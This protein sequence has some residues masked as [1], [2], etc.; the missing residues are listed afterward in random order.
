MK[1]FLVIG[2]PIE[3]SLSPKLH[4]YWFKSY[5]MN[6]IYG[7]LEASEK[8]LPELCKSIKKGDLDGLNVT[9]PFKKSIIPYLDILSGDALRTQSV[10]TISLV[11]GNLIGDNTDIEGFELSLKKINYDV[12]GKKVLILGAGGVVPS[13]ICALQ[14]M[15]AFKIFVSNR[16]KKKADHLKEMFEKIDVIEWGNLQEFDII[17]NATTLGL[18]ENDTFGLDFS[19][20]GENKFFY[21]VIYAP[22]STE[23][24]EAGSSQNNLS[25]NGFNMFLYQAQKAFNIW[26][27]I[28]PEINQELLGFLKN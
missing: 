23:F 8:D 17:I 21:D 26:H 18:K 4:N 14:R 16:T 7:K 6:G 24:S 11:K 12:C 10:N 28:E 15:N 20:Y 19:K 2:N 22:F 1:K 25:E 5:N 13:I 3:H 9:V 27:N